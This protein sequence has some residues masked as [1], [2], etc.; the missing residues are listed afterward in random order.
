MKHIS[1]LFM[2]MMGL[3]L[4]ANP[5]KAD[6]S[7]APP[8]TQADAQIH[9]AKEVVEYCVQKVC[10]D[11]CKTVQDSS[12]ASKCTPTDYCGPSS[13]AAGFPF[14]PQKTKDLCVGAMTDPN[15]LSSQR[16]EADWQ[17]SNKQ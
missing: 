16:R 12:C 9:C 15:P 14:D 2:A 11:Y 4:L 7:V 17:L 10:P 3:A 5:L 13:T 6:D 1:F 8:M